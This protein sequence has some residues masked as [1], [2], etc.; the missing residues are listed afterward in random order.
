MATPNWSNTMRVFMDPI[1]SNANKGGQLVI[2]SLVN[3]WSRGWLCYLTTPDPRPPSFRNRRDPHRGSRNQ[4]EQGVYSVVACLLNVAKHWLQ[5]R[6]TGYSVCLDFINR[7][8]YLSL[9]RKQIDGE[10]YI[11]RQ[12]RKTSIRNLYNSRL[13]VLRL[14]KPNFTINKT[15][16]YI[17]LIMIVQLVW[18]H[19]LHL[20]ISRVILIG[21]TKITC[22][23]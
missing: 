23:I 9:Y 8:K 2:C 12:L 4:R 19:L 15:H 18:K 1:I 14:V 3:D 20:P 10:E 21:Y 22:G 7:E 13:S 6:G 16:E 11:R 5:E 17:E